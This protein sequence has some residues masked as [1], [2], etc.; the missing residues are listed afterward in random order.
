MQDQFGFIC[1]QDG[2]WLIANIEKLWWISVII[3][4]LSVQW[5]C[6]EG[7]HK[8]TEDCFKA[9]REQKDMVDATAYCESEGTK[10]ARPLHDVD[11]RH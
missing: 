2:K 11:V 1:V 5:D 6:P 4:C 7:Y 9:V 10:L 3:I 8:L